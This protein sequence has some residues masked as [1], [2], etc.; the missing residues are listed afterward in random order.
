MELSEHSRHYL[1]NYYLLE[2]TRNETHAFLG[3][4]SE[5][6]YALID[7]HLKL[8]GDGVVTVEKYMQ[9]D[10]GN[11]WFTLRTRDD[12]PELARMKDWKY[13]IVYN[14]AMRT[15][16]LSDPTKGMIYG[17]TAKTSSAQI[18]EVRHA[19]TILALEDPYRKATEIDLLDG[20]VD[21]VVDH[22]AKVFVGY[23][24][25]YVQIVHSL[26]EAPES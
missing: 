4:I 8:K 20:P 21:E 10:G 16:D 17:F 11:I 26:A 15:Q 6:L 5:R 7:N 19:A 9:K 23:Y 25:D 1:E 22:L 2:Q 13:S 12:A 14:D 3:D 18:A 24:D